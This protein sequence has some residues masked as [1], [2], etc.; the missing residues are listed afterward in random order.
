MVIRNERILVTGAT[1]QIGQSLVRQLLA[2]SDD[3]RVRL[4]VRNAAVTRSLFANEESSGRI[5]YSQ[6]TNE[7]LLSLAV[8]LIDVDRL[9]LLTI[10]PV[11]EMEM[12]KVAEASGVKHIVKLSCIVATDRSSVDELVRQHMAVQ[13]LLAS[14]NVPFTVLWPGV[15]MEVRAQNGPKWSRADMKNCLFEQSL[16]P[17]GKETSSAYPEPLQHDYYEDGYLFAI[18]VR[19]AASCA[20]TV[21]TLPTESH[22]NKSYV[23][24]G[25]APDYCSLS[26]PQN[27]KAPPLHA[28]YLRYF[29]DSFLTN[30]AL[31]S[32]LGRDPIS[33]SEFL[34]SRIYSV[35]SLQPSTPCSIA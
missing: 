34:S 2:A 3:M 18:S 12:V 17:S 7:D 8:A 22:T 19:D 4:F 21:L 11:L 27:Q 23:L 32:I 6:G 30:N 20:A 24:S 35:S 14:V 15:F 9:F 33:W 1:G 13:S 28:C 31:K 5:E 25:F 10:K 26:F 16:L 29:G